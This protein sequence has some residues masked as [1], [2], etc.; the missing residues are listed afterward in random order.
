MKPTSTFLTAL[1]AVAISSAALAA[2]ETHG[3][4]PADM[5]PAV[6]ACQDFNLYASGGWIKANPIPADQSYWG[7]FTILEETN[8][9]NLH[10]VLEKVSKAQNAPGSDDQK[11]GDFYATC[12]DEAAIE[13]AGHH[14][15]QGRARDDRQDRRPRR[16]AGRDRAPPDDGRQRRLQLRLG[17]GPQERERGHRRR[18]PGR[19]GPARPRLLHEDRRRVEEAARPVPRPRH[20][21]VHPDGRRRREGRRERED[22]HGPRDEARRGVDDARRAPRPGQD[23]QPQDHDRARAA[24][25]ELLLDGVPEAARRSARPRDQRRPAEVLRGRQRAARR[26]AHRGLEDVPALAP[27]PLGGAQPVRRRSSTRASTSTRRPCRARPRTRSAG[28]AASA[29][30]TTRSASRSA[31]PT[32]AT[33]SRRR[34]RRAPTRWSRA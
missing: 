29:R 10:T 27:R 19:P 25:A 3:I 28:S 17:P 24:D 21:D 12:M 14:A 15:A 32:C 23:L 6:Q 22:G 18:L 11:V 26:D 31:R 4:N 30:P 34:P 7:S 5:D 1:A 8:K 33:I 2:P 13:A 20:E 16:A 9:A